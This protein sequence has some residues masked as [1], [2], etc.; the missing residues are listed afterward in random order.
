MA[1]NGNKRRTVMKRFMLIVAALITVVACATGA[2][3]KSLRPNSVFDDE[4]PPKVA[5]YLGNP[6]GEN[7]LLPGAFQGAVPQ[8]PHDITGMALD[9]ENNDC[10][11]CH[12]PAYEMEGVPYAPPTHMAGNELDMRRYQCQLC[13]VPQS[14]A[15]PL[16]MNENDSLA[17]ERQKK[18]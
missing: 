17:F 16:V 8:I 13:H 10:L 1:D 18:Q 12:H 11:N 5:K 4:M 2:N 14:D 15:L 9:T 3:V 7:Q 6:P